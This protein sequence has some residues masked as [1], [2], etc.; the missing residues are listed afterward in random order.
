MGYPFVQAKHY[1][2]GG[3]LPVHRIVIHDMEF[4]ERSTAA[5]D[6][7]AYFKRGPVRASAHYCCDNNSIV[8][9]VSEDDIAFHAPPN[10][11]SIGVELAGYAKQSPAEWRDPFSSAML[12]RA[13][14]LVAEVCTRHGVPPVW[15]TPADLKAGKRGITSHNNVSKAFGQSTHTD[16]GPAFPAGWFIDL[17]RAALGAPQPSPGGDDMPTTRLLRGRPDFP[18]HVFALRDN[19]L[20]HVQSPQTA[21]DIGYPTVKDANGHPVD[22][23]K[24]STTVP[25]GV[26]D[27]GPGGD[28]WYRLPIEVVEGEGP[29]ARLVVHPPLARPTP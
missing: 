20:A 23:A 3:N 26:E 12:H 21:E 29:A 5:E 17:V 25:N 9:C 27:I 15:L 7:A 22:I 16:P 4:P 13:A 18:I 6:V 19:K 10:S 11:H 8:Q 24:K 14:Q 28:V 2:D 1:R